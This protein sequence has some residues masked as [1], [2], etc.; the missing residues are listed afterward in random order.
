MT[1]Y[2]K[3]SSIADGSAVTSLGVTIGTP[4][5]P[6]NERFSDTRQPRAHRK[7]DATV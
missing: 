1:W 4:A 6:F 5:F 7:S 2:R 3:R